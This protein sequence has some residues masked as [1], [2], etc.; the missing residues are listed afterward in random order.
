MTYFSKTEQKLDNLL[1]EIWD[2]TD[3]RLAMLCYIENE[4]QRQ[5]VIDYIEKGNK[6]PEDITLFVLTITEKENE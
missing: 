3:F 4:E 1:K 5:N 6:K 2:D